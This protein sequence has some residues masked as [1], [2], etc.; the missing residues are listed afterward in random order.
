M[1]SSAPRIAFIIAPQQFRD[2]E[3]AVPRQYLQS[4]GWQCTTYSTQA[5]VA[6]G[7]LGAQEAVT[8]TLEALDVSTVEALAI[9]GG[10]GAVEHLWG[11]TTL[12]TL[13]QQAL[14]QGKVLGAICVSPVVLAKAG[15]LAGKSASVWP[16]PE[17]HAAFEAAGA[18]L[19]D[20]PVTTHGLV[21][22]ANGP[23]AALAFAHALQEALT[24]A[25]AAACPQ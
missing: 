23:E 17:S 12:H 13:C 2:E 16:M 14:A 7:M 19:S 21:V 9:V 15:V 20:D 22:T 11:N 6:Q 4:Q 18:L 5:G 10:Y 25:P 24:K 1:P 8:H 3:L